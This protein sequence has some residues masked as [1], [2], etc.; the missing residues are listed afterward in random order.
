MRDPLGFWK[1]AIGLALTLASFGTLA[2]AAT[3]PHTTYEF[4]SIG[5]A[6]GQIARLNVY[7]R[8]VF[9]PGPC[10]PGEVCSFPPGPCAPGTACTSPGPFRTT[11]SIYECDGSVSVQNVISLSGEKGGTLVF[12][13]RSFGGDNR[14][15]GRALVTVEPDANGFLPD[16]VP[17]VEILDANTGQTSLL[18]PGA[19]AG[20]NPQPEPPGD[21]NFGLF[22]IVRGQTARISASFISDREDLPPGPC[23]LILSFY[24][25]DGK[26]ISESAQSLEPGKTATFDYPTVDF[27]EGARQRIRAAVHVEGDERGL[28]PC[29]MPSIEVFASDT[30]KGTMYY[31]G[32][33]IGSD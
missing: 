4:A 12:A 18:N 19:I 22:N 13:P 2:N 5:V 10:K 31:P 1:H 9:P 17:S 30:G 16:L 6:R 20:F 32:S 25:G 3:A 26:L 11:L 24:S 23:R 14:A 21:Y 7:Y 28:V 8:N 33:L 15:C 29:I 27:P